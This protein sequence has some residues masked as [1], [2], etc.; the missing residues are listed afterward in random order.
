[1]PPPVHDRA[2]DLL[3]PLLGIGAVAG[4]DWPARA[5]RA[6]LALS[7]ESRQQNSLAIE[8]VNDVRRIFIQRQVE[9]LPSRDIVGGLARM[10]H[11]P[12]SD[13][14]SG[15][16]ITPVQ[17]ARILSELEIRPK[18]IRHGQREVGRGYRLLDL[19]PFRQ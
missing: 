2:Q 17:L 9:R 3:R 14:N 7:G 13:W 5:W 19:A 1:M 16:P 15:K 8:L 18:V 11:R 10:T 12:W 4:A 6:A